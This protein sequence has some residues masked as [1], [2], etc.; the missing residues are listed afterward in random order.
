M[1]FSPFGY[2][3][4]QVRAKTQHAIMKG[5]G[6]TG[7]CV[8]DAHYLSGTRFKIIIRDSAVSSCFFDVAIVVPHN[9]AAVYCEPKLKV[10]HR[11]SVAVLCIR[12]HSFED[13]FRYEMTRLPSSFTCSTAPLLP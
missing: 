3:H 9:D 6:S 4:N 1:T 12:A 7:E 13:P 11:H 8:R 2:L 10:R 5:A